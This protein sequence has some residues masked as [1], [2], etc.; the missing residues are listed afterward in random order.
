[1]QFLSEG[2]YVTNVVDGKVTV[3]RGEWKNHEM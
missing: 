1:M 3:Y 2:Q